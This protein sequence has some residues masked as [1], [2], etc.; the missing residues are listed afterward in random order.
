M[1]DSEITHLLDAARREGEAA[2]LAFRRALAL[3]PSSLE[4]WVNFASRRR[5]T[6]AARIATLLQPDSDT[7]QSNRSASLLADGQIADAILSALRA[8]ALA[9]HKAEGWNNLANAC[10]KTREDL[11]AETALIRALALAPD[12][13]ISLINLSGLLLDQGKIE[14]GGRLARLAVCLAPS[15]AAYNNLANG[16]LLA[17]RLAESERIFRR[18]LTLDPA[19][20]QAHFNS[21]APLLKQG[22]FTEGWAVYEARRETEAALKRQDFMDP[23]PHW[24]GGEL[25]DRRLLLS[26]EQGYGDGLQFCRFA[27]WLAAQGAKVTLRAPHSLL[28]LMRSLGADVEIIPLDATLPPFDAHLPAMSVPHFFPGAATAIPYLAVDPNLAALWRWRLQSLQGR[29]IGLVWSG[30]PRPGQR[31]AHLLDR[32]RSIPSE[33]FGFLNRMSNLS[34]VSLQKGAKTSA[35]ALQDWTNELS[36]FADTAA[37]IDGLDLV[38]SVDT[39]VAHLAGALGKPVWLLSRF[40]GCWRWGETGSDTYWYPQM[41][42]F[43]QTAPGDWREPLA[44]IAKAL[45]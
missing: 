10:L 17:N 11:R 22:K 6:N 25:R 23:K 32:R 28:R 5:G 30:D 15:A 1:C 35:L 43:R 41:R 8:V 18:A 20:R 45:A 33:E 34:L 2:D 39:A 37:L 29:K 12:F 38:I 13:T 7:A 14:T 31:A 26:L 24:Q 3:A 36:D 40:D 16:A 19:D 4:G 21:A 9:P 27:P 42:I 44:E